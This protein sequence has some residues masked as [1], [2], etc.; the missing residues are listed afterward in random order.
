MQTYL[1]K[2]IMTPGARVF[3]VDD[4]MARGTTL[5]RVGRSGSP[6]ERSHRGFWRRDREN[7][8]ERTPRMQRFGAPVHALVQVTSL[9]GGQ[10]HLA[11]DPG[12]AG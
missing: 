7:V 11:T 2:H 10:I 3:I 12:V 5:G 4:F 9:V 8:R 6:G 1:G